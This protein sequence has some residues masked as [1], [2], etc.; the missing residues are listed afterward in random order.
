MKRSKFIRFLT[1]S[2]LPFPQPWQ[3][4]LKEWI[5]RQKSLIPLVRGY[6]IYTMERI[7]PEVC[8]ETTSI[9]NAHCVMCP[10]DKLDRPKKPMDMELFKVFAAGQGAPSTANGLLEALFS[11]TGRW[12]PDE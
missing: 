10:I 2:R 4:K 8:V 6:R 3:R 11:L 9:C 1:G 12:G 7:P 5:M